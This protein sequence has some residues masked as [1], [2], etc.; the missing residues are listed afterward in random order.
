MVTSTLS[1][2]LADDTPPR[3]KSWEIEASLFVSIDVLDNHTGIRYAALEG[4]AAVAARGLLVIVTGAIHHLA[5]TAEDAESAL[6]PTTLEDLTKRFSFNEIKKKSLTAKL[7]TVLSNTVID[8][9][10]LLELGGV[11]LPLERHTRCDNVPS[12]TY[13]LTST[14]SCDKPYSD[15]RFCT[16]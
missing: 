3:Y 15:N 16:S 7:C 2:H 10:T 6:D 12:R 11:I 4:R 1:Q 13:I 5:H 9:A 8:K 14:I